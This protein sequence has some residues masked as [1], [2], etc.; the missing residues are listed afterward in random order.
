MGGPL[1]DTQ[2]TNVLLIDIAHIVITS[3][4]VSNRCMLIL[5]NCFHTAG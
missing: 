5:Y 4:V 2:V 3:N 1:D